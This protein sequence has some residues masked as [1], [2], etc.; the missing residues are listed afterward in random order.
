MLLLPLADRI[1][2]ILKISFSFV[3]Y[4]YIYIY[5]FLFL[6]LKFKVFQPKTAQTEKKKKGHEICFV[7]FC[8]LFEYCDELG[9]LD[10]ITTA[11]RNDTLT[12][13]EHTTHKIRIKKRKTKQTKN[14]S[15]SHKTTKLAHR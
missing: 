12:E 10:K 15:T 2:L 1:E 13:L 9:G 11:S 5:I 6:F 3:L 14:K 7:L 8:C 4:I